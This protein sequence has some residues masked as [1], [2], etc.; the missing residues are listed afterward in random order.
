MGMKEAITSSEFG[1]ICSGGKRKP[2]LPFNEFNPNE[3]DLNLTHTSRS[4]PH[5]TYI[6][7]QNNKLGPLSLSS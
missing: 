2:Y 4:S 1:S 5:T 3:H 7:Y 6:S